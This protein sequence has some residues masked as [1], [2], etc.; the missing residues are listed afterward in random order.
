MLFAVLAAY[1]SLR[2]LLTTLV[3]HTDRVLYIPNDNIA[4]NRHKII[5]MVLM[6]LDP[7]QT[8]SHSN[9]IH[10][11]FLQILYLQRQLY[12]LLFLT[13]LSR[14]DFPA[15]V[16]QLVQAIDVLITGIRLVFLDLGSH[17]Q[18]HLILTQCLG[19]LLILNLHHLGFETV[20]LHTVVH[21]HPRTVIFVL[22]P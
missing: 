16:L 18:L 1:D 9:V 11:I 13:L 3:A 8:S 4:I 14:E 21:F 2:I 20:T 5:C 7:L 15:L 12:L 10:N 17:L 19:Q 22:I 6:V